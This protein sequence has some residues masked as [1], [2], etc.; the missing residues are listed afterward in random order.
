M[1]RKI[2]QTPFSRDHLPAQGVL[3]EEQ[4]SENISNPV[5]I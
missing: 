4:L 5:F 2:V 3:P 1:I